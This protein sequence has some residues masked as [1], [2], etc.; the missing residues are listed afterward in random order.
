MPALR[1]VDDRQREL[2]FLRP[3]GRIVSLVPS[4]TVL[5]P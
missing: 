2:V 5:V 1:I 4:D 3:P